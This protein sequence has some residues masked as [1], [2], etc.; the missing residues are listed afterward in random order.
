MDGDVLRQTL[1][2]KTCK[3][4]SALHDVIWAQTELVIAETL[5]HSN[6][7]FSLYHMKLLV[8]VPYTNLYID[9][10]KNFRFRTK[11]DRSV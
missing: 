11:L 4:N 5:Q 8:A 2:L 1:K 3:Q 9:N 10:V 7:K 6:I